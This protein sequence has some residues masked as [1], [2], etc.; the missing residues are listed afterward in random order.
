MASVPVVRVGVGVLLCRRGKVLVGCRKGSHGSGTYALPGG[1]L[2][3]GETWEE[4]ARREVQ[5]ET[6]IALPHDKFSFAHVSN[7]IMKDDNKH[8]ITIFMKADVPDDVEAENMEPNKCLGWEWADW[9]DLPSPRFIPLDNL[10]A[11][12]FSPFPQEV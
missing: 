2:E 10:L 6:A 4:C 7:D 12:G 3:V 11:S 8:Y 5:E 1:H 9:P